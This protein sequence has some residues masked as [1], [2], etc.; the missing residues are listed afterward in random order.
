MKHFWKGFEGI[1]SAAPVRFKKHVIVLYWSSDDSSG[2]SAK[3][4]IKRLSIRHPS[5]AV[6]T[7]DTKKDP[8]LPMKHRVLDLPTVVL[9]KD[10]REIDRLNLRKEGSLLEHLFRKASV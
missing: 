6:K 4:A 5:V 1:K 3:E 7:I 8:S 10:G 9:L 2:A